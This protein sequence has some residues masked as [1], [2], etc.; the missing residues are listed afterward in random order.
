MPSPRQWLWFVCLWAAGVGA[1][2]AV[3]FVI[4]LWLKA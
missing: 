3:G 2:A 1:V 4:K